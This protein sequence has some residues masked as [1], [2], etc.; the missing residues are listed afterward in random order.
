MS[1]DWSVALSLSEVSDEGVIIGDPND[2]TDAAAQMTVWTMGGVDGDASG[3]WSGNLAEAGEDTVPM[4]A[5]GTFY[6]E[7]GRDGKMVGAFGANL[8]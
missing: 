7:F 5:T 4:V 8:D 3:Q 2:N 1:R 6:S